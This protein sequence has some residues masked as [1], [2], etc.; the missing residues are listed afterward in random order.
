MPHPI[1]GGSSSGYTPRANARTSSIACSDLLSESVQ[2]HAGFRI[3]SLLEAHSSEV[4]S[5]PKS[6]QTLLNSVVE[7]SLD[8]LTIGVSGS[9]HAAHQP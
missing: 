6:G 3:A 2:S 9:E 1:L 5:D 7:V 8:A 4:E